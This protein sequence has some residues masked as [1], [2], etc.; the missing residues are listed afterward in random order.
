MTNTVNERLIK[1]ADLGQ[2]LPDNRGLDINY[3]FSNGLI[4]RT[5]M[6]FL[7]NNKKFQKVYSLKG[8]IPFS[9]N[10]ESL[11]FN[12][13]FN[14]IEYI[15]ESNIP[16]NLDGI[17]VN[18]P[19]TTVPYQFNEPVDIRYSNVG[20]IDVTRLERALEKALSMLSENGSLFLVF[21]MMDI[22]T[23]FDSRADRNSGIHHNYKNET[24][25]VIESELRPSLKEWK[26]LYSIFTKFN[27]TVDSIIKTDDDPNYDAP[28]FEGD[29]YLDSGGLIILRKVDAVHK[30]L[31]SVINLT[32]SFIDINDSFLYRLV[33]STVQGKVITQENLIFE[34]VN[35]NVEFNGYL[36]DA[37]NESV[38]YTKQKEQM[39]Q[40]FKSFTCSD[41]VNS[42]KH[43]DVF[44]NTGFEGT[45]YSIYIPLDENM[46]L[47]THIA[48]SINDFDEIL[49]KKHAKYNWLT[50]NRIPWYTYILQVL[51]DPTTSKDKKEQL[52]QVFDKFNTTE[53]NIYNFFDI[54]QFGFEFDD[55][56]ILYEGNTVQELDIEKD[57]DHALKIQVLKANV[58]EANLN[59]KI[60]LPAYLKLLMNTHAGRIFFRDLRF[61]D[62][63]D[64][65][66]SVFLD[67]MLTIPTVELQKKILKHNVYLE[68]QSQLLNKQKE[69]FYDYIGGGEF[70]SEVFKFV[71]KYDFGTPDAMHSLLSSIPQPIASILY[72]DGCE[73]NIARKNINS[74]HLFEA[75]AQ[76]HATVLLSIIKTQPECKEVFDKIMT[77]N[78]LRDVTAFRWE[79]RSVF[80]LW[81]TLIE[82]VELN[83]ANYIP[84]DK[85]LN[86][87][88]RI[89]LQDA[90]DL[91]N[92]KM[93]HAPRW[94]NVKEKKL[95][96][97]LKTRVKD[98]MNY[99]VQLYRGYELITGPFI[100]KDS[101]SENN[102]A[103][104]HCYKAVGPNPR[105]IREV[106]EVSGNTRFL[107]HRLYLVEI[108]SWNKPVE[109]LPL[110]NYMPL[111]QDDDQL[112]SLYYFHS[113]NLRTDGITDNRSVDWCSYDCGDISINTV[114]YEADLATKD[115][116]DFLRPYWENKVKKS[117]I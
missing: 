27:L 17:I 104:V 76:F 22:E 26:G 42:I 90:Q 70:S 12:Q 71:D 117:K 99:F 30:P 13:K 58:F 72:L 5:I 114:G 87:D 73:E 86:T 20:R 81:T 21:R 82:Q 116:M 88:F 67:T 96:I 3:E 94:S 103:Y 35:R 60:I 100:R 43:Y 61:K 18:V 85:Q 7:A 59:T 97:D 9:S 74:F 65:I 106:L 109:L 92:K 84:F 102:T 32:E 19:Y 29:D 36:N 105:F 69:L 98:I 45:E 44:S 56:V 62:K 52:K 6:S 33:K 11:I 95:N 112:K 63:D 23:H 46:L 48:Y 16:D 4:A 24:E 108:G 47:T 110:V 78:F 15:D 53:W 49:S 66:E 25:F 1:I 28:G 10:L 14:D 37:K 115:L 54:T 75:I 93:A 8:F 34:Y 55:N 2:Y 101:V 80:G 38:F 50:W 41:L 68:Y 111:C 77:E 83:C 107:D 39:A 113:A 64:H 79:I 40:G 89:L 57:I 31:Y 91:R 51:N